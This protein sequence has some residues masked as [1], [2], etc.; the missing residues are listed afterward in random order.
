MYVFSIRVYTPTCLT[1]LRRE[2]SYGLVCLFVYVYETLHIH[3]CMQMCV[4]VYEISIYAC[5]HPQIHGGKFHVAGM[6]SLCM[7]TCMYVKPQ[8]HTCMF[9]QRICI[10]TSLPPSHI[11]NIICLPPSHIRNIICLPPSHTR[12]IICLPPSHTRNIIWS[13]LLLCLCMTKHTHT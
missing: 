8:T 9:V 1:V 10:P 3:I 4:C 11:R 7:Y 13:R 2:I 5:I 12:N 6:V